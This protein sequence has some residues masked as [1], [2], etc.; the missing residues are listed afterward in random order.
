[1]REEIKLRV[2]EHHRNAIAVMLL[3]PQIMRSTALGQTCRTSAHGRVR[4]FRDKLS[5]WAAWS[6]SFPPSSVCQRLYRGARRTAWN[7]GLKG[8][9]K[10]KKKLQEWSHLAGRTDI[11]TRSQ[12][13]VLHP[14]TNPDSYCSQLSSHTIH[15]SLHSF[16]KSQNI[17]AV[18]VAC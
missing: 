5:A 7:T 1:M 18:S 15:R 11:W 8:R 3:P 14:T 10:K 6:R 12:L 2:S 17:S 4:L 9:I 13:N 16:K